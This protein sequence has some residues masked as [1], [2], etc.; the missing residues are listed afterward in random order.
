MAGN[1][2]RGKHLYLC[3]AQ[4]VINCLLRKYFIFDLLCEIFGLGSYD[5]SI[6]AKMVKV[7]HKDEQ[8]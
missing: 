1:I 7:Y 8:M 3:V 6:D 5:L 2:H 4:T